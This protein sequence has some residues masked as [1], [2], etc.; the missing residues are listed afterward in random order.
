MCGVL[1]GESAMVGAG[2]LVTH[3]VQEHSLVVGSPARVRTVRA[4][5]R[6]I[7]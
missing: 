2:A 1:I 7:L 5:R 4:I 3:N 6:R